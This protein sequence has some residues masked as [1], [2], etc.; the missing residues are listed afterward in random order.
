MV[1]RIWWK[2][3]LQFD[4]SNQVRVGWGGGVLDRRVFEWHRFAFFFFFLWLR[5][6]KINPFRTTGRHTSHAIR[7]NWCQ[8][9]VKRRKGRSGT[10]HKHT[11]SYN[12]GKMREKEEDGGGGGGNA[13]HDTRRMSRGWQG[14]NATP[15]PSPSPLTRAIGWHALAWRRCQ[16]ANEERHWTMEGGGERGGWEKQRRKEGKRSCSWGTES[17]R[18]WPNTHFVWEIWPNRRNFVQADLFTKKLKSLFPLCF[19]P[20]FY[21]WC[22]VIIR[23]STLIFS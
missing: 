8:D 15:P 18:T 10:R 11:H 22:E 19:F 2:S 12:R 21:R 1:T 9:D 4:C 7:R 6:N 20:L 23:I 16:H 17:R 13:C 3:P 14:C 5:G